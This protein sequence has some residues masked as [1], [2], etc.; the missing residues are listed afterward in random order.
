PT[1]PNPARDARAMAAMFQKSG[2]DVVSAL[3]DTGNLEFKRA[4]RQFEDAAT[5]ADIAVIYFAGHGIE[6]HGVNYLVPADA[7]LASDRDADDEAITLDRLLVPLSGAKKLLLVIL[8]SCRDDPFVRKMM[9][10]RS[11]ALRGSIPDWQRS[12][13]PPAIR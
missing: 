11:A 5:G 4:I 8:D 3:Y 13:R 12:S 7:K 10:Q 1:L 6:I 2:F 9:Q